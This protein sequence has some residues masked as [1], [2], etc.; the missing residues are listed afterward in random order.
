MLSGLFFGSVESKN[1][2]SSAEDG[3]VSQPLAGSPD[4]LDVVELEGL[5]YCLNQWGTLSSQPKEN[6][7]IYKRFL[8]HYSRTQEPR[9]PV[10]PEFAPVYPL[11]L[12]AAKLA[13][14]RMKR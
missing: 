1:V 14:R 6:Q 8:F 2:K 7:D 5:V 12:L 11:M 3:G 4:G 10:N 13:S 9:Y